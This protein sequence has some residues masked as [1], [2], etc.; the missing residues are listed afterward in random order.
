MRAAIDSRSDLRDREEALRDP[1]F[2]DGAEDLSPAVANVNSAAAVVEIGRYEANYFDGSEVGLEA[3]D[4]DLEHITDMVKQGYV[5]GE[6]V[7]EDEED[8]H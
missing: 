8:T 7:K 2:I 6:L 1:F 4:Q 3:G 5:E